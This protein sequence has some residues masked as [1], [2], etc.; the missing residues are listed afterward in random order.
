MSQ[1]NYASATEEQLASINN[2]LAKGD[3]IDVIKWAYKTFSDDLIYSCSFGA[4]AMVLLDMI[5]DVK[6]DAKVTF[7]DTNLHFS[8]TY[9]LIEQVRAR[10]PALRITV[11]QPDITLAQQAD[12]HGEELWS[13]QPDMCC[14]IR[15]VQPMESV[16]TGAV[17]WLSGLR[18]EQ[19]A[20]RAD[21]EFI[22]RDE[23]FQSLKI[24]P[25]IH[26]KSE[27]VWQYI[28]AFELPYN[29][30]HDQS[31]PSIGCAPCTRPVK[32]GEDSRAGRWGQAGKTECGLHLA[33]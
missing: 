15:K 22:N 20:T 4:E 29:P 32:E 1:L 30:L 19:S 16:L 17:A 3:T 18:R 21:V 25:L 31:Y 8:E 23:K 11:K 13:K 6:K 26:W 9:S 28:R 7:L 2:S 33:R 10:Y 12:L 27:E 5:S 14:H 24:C